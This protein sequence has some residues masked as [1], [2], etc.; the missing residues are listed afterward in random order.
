V[1]SH[2]QFNTKIGFDSYK[3]KLLD[4]LAFCIYKFTASM[5]YGRYVRVNNF[6]SIAREKK[7]LKGMVYK[8]FT[9]AVEYKLKIDLTLL[10]IAIAFCTLE[11][12]II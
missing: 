10:G 11:N 4:I 1:D 2:I 6:L 5:R 12:G 7:S 8:S 9:F 3:A